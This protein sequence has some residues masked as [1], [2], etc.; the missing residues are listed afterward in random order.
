LGQLEAEEFLNCPS[1][2]L[3]ALKTAVTPKQ[4]SSK[5]QKKGETMVFIPTKQ[6]SLSAAALLLASALVA[7]T[8]AIAQPIFQPGTYGDFDRLDVF[9]KQSYIR[10]CRDINLT[11]PRAEVYASSDMQYGKVTQPIHT[12]SPGTQVR[13]TGILQGNPENYAAA[14][15]Y[16]NGNSLSNNHAVGWVNVDKLT[17]T[18]Q[19]CSP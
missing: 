6:R 17:P 11:V 18:T 10:D 16:L 15:I 5:F 14:Q 13:L 3:T 4:L 2:Y 7:G 19:Y 8:Y 9:E 1:L 12:L